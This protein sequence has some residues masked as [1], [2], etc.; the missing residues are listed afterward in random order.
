MYVHHMHSWWLRRLGEVVVDSLELGTHCCELLSC[1]RSS[2]KLQVLLTVES[3]LQPWGIFWITFNFC[4]RIVWTRLCFQTSPGCVLTVLIF[5][6]L[7][8][9]PLLYVIHLSSFAFVFCDLGSYAI[10][11]RIAQQHWAILLY[12]LLTFHGF[13]YY[14]FSA[15]FG[16]WWN[17]V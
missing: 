1:C 2:E 9:K 11:L 6:W 8:E 13:A 14:S 7:V 5:H 15:D 16:I 17:A 12:F 4:Y 10:S 3:S